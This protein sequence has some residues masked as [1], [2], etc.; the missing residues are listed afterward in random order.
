MLTLLAIALTVGVLVWLT[1]RRE[2]EHFGGGPA[3]GLTSG[4]WWSAVAMTQAG[5]AQGGPTSLPGRLLA[6]VWMIASIISLAVFT[7]GI[8]SSLT[9][10]EMHGL[11]RN[12]GDL[13]GL[14]VG[15]VQGSSTEDFLRKQR[16]ASRSYA[17]PN[18]GLRAV[19]TGQLDAFVYDRPLLSWIVRQ[20][21]PEIQ[22]LSVTFDPQTYAIGLQSGSKLQIP[23]DILLLDTL[24]SDWWQGTQFR[25]LGRAAV[26]E[27]GG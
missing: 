2:N 23:L 17:D 11:V 3:R 18:A 7:A 6:V 24:P 9:T 1:E 10:R 4:V 15:S 5:A 22:V 25:Y 20:D 27:S 8:T 26:P 12:L 13:R 19:Q 16:I 14:R 21:F